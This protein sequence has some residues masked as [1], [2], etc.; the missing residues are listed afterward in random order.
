MLVA[1]C[2]A[3]IISQPRDSEYPI[4]EGIRSYE[5]LLKRGEISSLRAYFG[6][7]CSKKKNPKEK[8]GKDNAKFARKV[9]DVFVTWNSCNNSGVTEK[10]GIERE[11][12]PTIEER[13]KDFFKSLYGLNEIPEDVPKHQYDDT[14]KFFFMGFAACMT[15]AN[16]DVVGL[17]D[18]QKR[19]EV[20]M[21]E[22]ELL[23]FIG[24]NFKHWEIQDER[25]D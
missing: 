17:S 18:V 2:D 20:Y 8:K 13:F 22:R 24:K 11:E 23:T 5:E 6:Y 4:K 3:Y 19:F 16:R 15:F 10:K 14:Q 12:L 7:K 21:V 1:E 25:T 9:N